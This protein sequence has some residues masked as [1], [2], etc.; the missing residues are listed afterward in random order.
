MSNNVPV[1]EW[2]KK[3]SVVFAI[4]A[5][6]SERMLFRM[7]YNNAGDLYLSP[8]INS[9]SG[10]VVKVQEAIVVTREQMDSGIQFG[11]DDLALHGY[12]SFHV[13]GIVKGP[14]FKQ[15]PNPYDSGRH[16]IKELTE[17]VE[18][19]EQRLADPGAYPQ[20][21]D[22]DRAKQ[23]IIFIPSAPAPG[24][25]PIIFIEFIPAILLAALPTSNDYLVGLLADDVPEAV[26]FVAFIRVA[27]VL[28]EIP[29]HHQITFKRRQAT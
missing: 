14:D 21:S 7:Y 19:C 3:K 11:E 18:V 8:L 29:E 4:R 6:E 12:V 15:R 27:Y 1:Y 16:S 10:A 28:G 23:N 13:S 5:Q 26:R 22:A 9:K 17:V 24:V 20:V 2:K 25:V